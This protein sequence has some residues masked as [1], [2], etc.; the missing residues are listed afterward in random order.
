MSLVSCLMSLVMC[1]AC[2]V[3]FPVSCA[4][5]SL[6]CPFQSRVPL[7]VSCLVGLVSQLFL[8]VPSV[9]CLSPIWCDIAVLSRLSVVYRLFLGLASLVCHPSRL[10]P[11]W[12]VIGLACLLCQE[13]HSK[14]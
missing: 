6:V 13:I 8:G 7:S 2:R 11:I 9:S 14:P 12:C 1:L 3:P 4:L 10:S 5:V